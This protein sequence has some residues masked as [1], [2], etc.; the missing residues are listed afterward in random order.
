MSQQPS[1][2]AFIDVLGSIFSFLGSIQWSLRFSQLLSI[3]YFPFRLI[4]YPLRLIVDVLLVV[5]APA[6]YVFS[7]ILSLIRSVFDFL[8]SLEVR[9]LQWL[10][11]V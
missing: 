1:S 2:S 5:F 9:A 7:F 11:A 6:I 8:A 3:L 4:I 10:K